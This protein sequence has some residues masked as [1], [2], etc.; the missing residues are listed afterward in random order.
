MKAIFHWP[1]LDA[2]IIYPDPDYYHLKGHDFM[3][4][5]EAYPTSIEYGRSWVPI[6]EQGYNPSGE[7]HGDAWVSYKL[8]VNEHYG[9][10][11]GGRMRRIRITSTER[12]HRVSKTNGDHLR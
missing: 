7:H 5:F 1:F 8:E 12:E 2:G 11:S 9:L 6:L 3:I 4:T 10:L